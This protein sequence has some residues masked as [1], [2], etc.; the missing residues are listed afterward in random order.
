MEEMLKGIP[1][2]INHEDDKNI[3]HKIKDK[4]ILEVILDMEHDKAPSPNGFT[5]IF[6]KSFWHIIKDDLWR[7]INYSKKKKVKLGGAT[8]SSFLALILKEK[9]PTSFSQLGKYICAIPLT[10][11]SQRLL[12]IE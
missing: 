6:Y 3:Y 5:T 1:T 12:L 9:N 2:L 7:M 11:F 10:R 4:E 8:N